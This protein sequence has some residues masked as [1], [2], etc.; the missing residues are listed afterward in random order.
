MGVH[1]H[2][3]NQVHNKDRDRVIELY[4]YV[5]QSVIHEQCLSLVHP[6]HDYTTTLVY[7]FKILVNSKALISLEPQ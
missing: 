1:V 3:V 5:G 6:L 4:E 2:V 7:H